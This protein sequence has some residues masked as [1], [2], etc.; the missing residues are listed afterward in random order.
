[1]S[2]ILRHRPEVINIEMEPDGWVNT[3]ELIEK[4]NLKQ[5]TW[6]LDRDQLDE[7]VATNNKKR[8][9]FNDSGSKIRASQGHSLNVDLEYS[10]I[11]PPDYLYHGTASKNVQ[12]I[13]TNGLMSKTRLHVH[14]TDDRT[15]AVQVGGRH[16][17]PV[18]LTIRST[19]MVN[20][21]F[22]FYKSENGVWLTKHVPPSFIENGK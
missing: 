8:F 4:I 19:A 15:T 7:I 21:G 17:K 20:A 3:D 1:M 6:N 5:P 12:G 14:L 22:E 10:P 11:T 2:L 13:R 16:G 9:A 18:V